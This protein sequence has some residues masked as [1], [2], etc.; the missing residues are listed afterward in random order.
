MGNSN[1]ANPKLNLHIETEKP[2]YNSGSV[3]EGVVFVDAK[4]V[5]HFDAL[6]IRV[7]GIYSFIQV[8]SIANGLKEVQRIEENIQE[9]KI[10]MPLS[11]CSPNS[12]IVLYI[13]E[14]LH[15]RFHYNCHK[16]S[17]GHSNQTNTKPRFN[18]NLLHIVLTSMIQN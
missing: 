1:P 13:K 9:I 6:Y 15:I 5:F 8:I 10:F 4:D 12:K 18:T 14:N 11:T 16:I 3:V 2:F 17:L 7:E